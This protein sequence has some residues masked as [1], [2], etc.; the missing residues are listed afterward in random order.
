MVTIPFVRHNYNV[1]TEVTPQYDFFENCLN[2]L[3]WWLSL[4]RPAVAG[5][6]SSLCHIV[7]AF[8]ALVH[9]ALG[10]V[11]LHGDVIK[12]KHFPRY[13]PVVRR[14]HRSPVNSL[15]KGQLR[16]ALMFSLICASINGWANNREAGELKRHRAH[17][18]VIVMDKHFHGI[19]AQLNRRDFTRG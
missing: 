14:I 18:D 19:F 15:H 11:I 4:Y 13:W 3:K 1:W 10:A 2:N 5:L 9:G 16:R 8:H 17:Y 12:W 7:I 6:L